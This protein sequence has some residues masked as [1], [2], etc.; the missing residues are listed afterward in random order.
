MG[1]QGYSRWDPIWDPIWDPFWRPGIAFCTRILIFQKM[2]NRDFTDLGPILAFQNAIL[3]DLALQMGY[4]RQALNGAPF[5]TPFGTL[6]GAVTGGVK[7]GCI[8]STWATA[9]ETSRH[10]FIITSEG[11]SRY[12]LND[13]YLGPYLG[14]QKG[15][16]RGSERVKC[17]FE[18]CKTRLSLLAG[19]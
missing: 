1:Y 8:P 6:S 12:P 10:P 3:G 18:L 7:Q 4:P 17:M 9:V 2:R 15:A 5:G 13:P 16:K 11:A 19:F 14:P